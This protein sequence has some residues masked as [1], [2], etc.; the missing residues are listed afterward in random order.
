MSIRDS[1]RP[2]RDTRGDRRGPSP[3]TVRVDQD[4]TPQYKQDERDRE[5][6]QPAARNHGSLA[7]LHRHAGN[8]A[9]AKLIADRT[10]EVT[11]PSDPVETHAREAVGS[12]HSAGA[13][14]ERNQRGSQP[15]AATHSADLRGLAAVL[16]TSSGGKPLSDAARAGIGEPD[17]MSWGSV[18]V[19]EGPVA[20]TVTDALQARAATAGEHVYFRTGAYAPTTASGRQLLAHELTHV[21]QFRSGRLDQVARQ[22]VGTAERRTGEF[23]DDAEPERLQGLLRESFT[24]VLAGTLTGADGGTTARPTAEDLTGIDPFLQTAQARIE[25]TYPP[26]VASRLVAALRRA[27]GIR[28]S[29]G[30]LT[31]NPVSAG[32][33][34]AWFLGVPPALADHSP[35]SHGVALYT[36]LVSEHLAAYLLG[37]ARDP[38]SREAATDAGLEFLNAQF[39]GLLARWDNPAGLVELE[40]EGVINAIVDR[41]ERLAEVTDEQRREAIRGEIEGLSRRALLLDDAAAELRDIGDARTDES[42][43]DRELSDQARRIDAIAERVDAALPAPGTAVSEERTLEALGGGRHLLGVQ[44]ID[45]TAPLTEAG[46][47]SDRIEPEQAFPATTERAVSEMTASLDERLQELEAT[48]TEMRQEVIP[49]D[50][51]YSLN[52]F[53]EVYRNWVAFYSPAAREA[54][55]FYGQ[56]DTLFTELSQAWGQVGGVEGGL[57]RY[58]QQGLIA[59][60]L[61]LPGASTDFASELSSERPTVQERTGGT[62]FAPRYEFGAMFGD[63]RAIGPRGEAASRRRHLREQMEERATAF[64]DVR[65]PSAETPV[66]EAT[67]EAGLVSAER[68]SPAV[69]LDEPNTDRWQYLLSTQV[70]PQLG[71]DR[72]VHEQRGV[73]PEVAEYL[74]ARE[75][76]EAARQASHIPTAERPT[77]ETIPIGT[78]ATRT[79]GLRGRSDELSNDSEGDRS[80]PPAPEELVAD[81]T[82]SL[83]A[84]IDTFLETGRGAERIAATYMIAAAEYRGEERFAAHFDAASIAKA[85]AQAVG[86]AT[87]LAGLRVVG[88]RLGKAL[89]QGLSRMMTYMG[90]RGDAATLMAVAGWFDRTAEVSGFRQARTMG[91]IASDL[92]DEIGAIVLDHATDVGVDFARAGHRMRSVPETREELLDSLEPIVDKDMPRAHLR[93][94]VAAERQAAAEAQEQRRQSDPEVAALADFEQALTGRY[95]QS[96][97]R[98]RPDRQLEHRGPTESHRLLEHQFLEFRELVGPNGRFQLT[99]LEAGY[100]RYRA[101]KGD[102][103]VGR[104]EWAMRQTTGRPREILEAQLGPNYARRSQSQGSGGVQA[105]HRGRVG[106][107]LAQHALAAEGHELVLFHAGLEGITQRGVD[108]VTIRDDHVYLIDNKAHTASGTVGKATSLTENLDYNIREQVRPTLE[109]IATDESYPAEARELHQRALAA[110]DRGDVTKAVTAANIAPD[111]RLKTDVSQRLEDESVEFIDLMDAN[112]LD[113]SEIPTTVGDL[114]T[115]DGSRFVDDELEGYYQRHLEI[116]DNL[117]QE[118]M[119]REEWAVSL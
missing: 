33:L 3:R 106:E 94:A 103:A 114:L 78:H 52:E 98:A 53:A 66:A 99:E 60:Y 80:A 14:R 118:P 5:T 9:V 42:A 7:A 115:A 41:R 4:R 67:V 65:D 116:M 50:P 108:I 75:Q 30:E 71:V 105:H 23:V 22:A 87:L 49:S 48:V 97:S 84:Y 56:L 90:L 34:L 63:D 18:R 12:V 1:D 17:G 95:R 76:L 43:L 117:G 85:V 102:D 57:F 31:L 20:Q 110:I 40:L 73:P 2:D 100:E 81:L 35:A 111:S 96:V 59:S 38:G 86:L 16:G 72:W 79:Q 45:L 44:E 92:L 70:Q 54:D 112:E 39:S 62:A 10:D 32:E 51:S 69:K 36:R 68:A 82:E 77:G 29:L 74:L 21:A 109:R 89:S 37:A 24:A 47:E 113:S 91:Y 15:G 11:A 26:E 107:T 61:P 55:M 93:D 6:G 83:E 8:Q 58:H 104:R 28:A 27:G 64:A 119:S 46:I 101:R 88:G 13:T 25:A 19:H